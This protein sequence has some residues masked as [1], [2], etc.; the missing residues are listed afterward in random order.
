M[1]GLKTIASHGVAIL[2]RNNSQ[3]DAHPS[4]G[5][6]SSKQSDRK[7]RIV[8]GKSTS[9]ATHDAGKT[10]TSKA[11]HSKISSSDGKILA[12]VTSRSGMAFGTCQANSGG[13]ANNNQAMSVLRQGLQNQKEHGLEGK[14]LPPKLQDGSTTKT[15]KSISY[16]EASQDVYC[17]SVLDTS[18]FVLG[19]GCVVHNCDA[20]RYLCK[21]RL[22]DSKW[23]QPAEVF[24]KGVIKLQAYIAQM[25]AQANRARI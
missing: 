7:L 20:L 4:Q 16:F 13:D 17:L 9:I 22:I 18:N 19:N 5:R 1:Q 10:R 24:N 21:E 6:E 8:N 15:V 25:R 11:K 23:E 2:Q 3:R 12:Q 14:V